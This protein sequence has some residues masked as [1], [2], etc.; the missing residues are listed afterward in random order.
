MDVVVAKKVG[1]KKYNKH[2]QEIIPCR[3]CGAGTTMTGT[4]LCDRC[5]EL[6][7]LI[8]LDKRV[9]QKIM[10]SMEV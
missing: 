9:A 10:A 4:R 2:G 6:Q 1:D 8:S 3:F 7:R 5:W